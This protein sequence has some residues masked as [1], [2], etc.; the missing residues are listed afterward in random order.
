MLLFIVRII[1]YALAIS[2]LLG[3]I[4]FMIWIVSELVSIFFAF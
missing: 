4:W 2:F 3:V 1:G